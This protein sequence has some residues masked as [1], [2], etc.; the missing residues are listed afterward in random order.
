MQQPHYGHGEVIVGLGKNCR[1]V[2]IRKCCLHWRTP[3]RRTKSDPLAGPSEKLAHKIEDVKY[4]KKFSGPVHQCGQALSV[5][6]TECSVDV[7]CWF[8]VVEFAGHV[9]EGVLDERGVYGVQHAR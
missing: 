3:I 6:A 9:V 7:L 2:Q 8:P 1:Y 5:V 4:D